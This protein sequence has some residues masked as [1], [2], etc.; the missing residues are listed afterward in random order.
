MLCNEEKKFFFRFPGG[1]ALLCPRLE[2]ITDYIGSDYKIYE[3]LCS[4]TVND[5]RVDPSFF[6]VH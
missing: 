2:L 1:E 3:L 4:V 5:S 6:L